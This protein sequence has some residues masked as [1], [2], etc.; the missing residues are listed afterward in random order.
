MSSM[1]QSGGVAAESPPEMGPERLS[2]A[3]QELYRSLH[4]ATIYP[5]GH[6]EAAVAVA[7]AHRALLE[8]LP[9]RGE[10]VI[11]VIAEADGPAFVTGHANSNAFLV[12]APGNQDRV[13]GMYHIRGMAYCPPR[14]VA[15]Q[16]A[17][18]IIPVH[19]D[20]IH[21]RLGRD[22]QGHE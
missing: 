21:C 19:C 14:L 3:L 6:P 2:S 10:A 15:A 5:E 8:A 11:G 9:S 22:G 17:P 7:R 20:I 1:G 4:T 13:A 12:G 16:T 18:G